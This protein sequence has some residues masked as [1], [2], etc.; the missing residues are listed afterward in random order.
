MDT[1]VEKLGPSRYRLTVK[2]SASEVDE[3]IDQAYKRLARKVKIPGFRAGKAPKPVIDTHIGREAVIADA[4]D[5]LLNESYGR[6]L[7]VEDIRPIANPE[8]GELDLM[9]A[10][11]E[12]E[13]VAEVDVR[14]E[15]TIS[16]PDGLTVT[17]P[18]SQ[19]TDREIDAQIE[20]TRERFATL[21]PVED[22]PVAADDFVLLSFVG[23]IEG[24]A[25]EGNTVDRYLYE[26]NRG[27]M[28]EEFDQAL[29]GTEAGGETVAT[30][31]IP[32]SSSEPKYVGKMAE[33]KITVHEIKAKV[34]PEVDDE[35]AGNV[36]GYENVEEMR[37]A[38]RDQMNKSKAVGHMREVER[39][40]RAALAERLEGEI[41]D[42]MIQSTRSQM[43]R[44]FVSGLESRGIS[45]PDYFKATGGSLGDLE[46]GIAEQAEQAVREELAMEALFRH[47]GWE[48]TDEDIDAEIAE[49]ASSSEADPAELRAKWEET[50]VIAVLR[51]QIM[52]RRAA[53]WLVDPANVTVV[54]TDDP[55]ELAKSRGVQ[56]AE[57]TGT[58]E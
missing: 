17:V 58:E 52:Q 47:M 25:Y 5:E 36:G 6:A 57:E 38:L 35:L 44:D 34:L 23:T 21:E 19:A 50:G 43:M 56:T 11:K 27:L 46:E 42:A 20:H 22:R 53:Q 18:P 41:P 54:E 4:Q 26:M 30:F 37:T 33:F 8:I 3:A 32:A 7:D 14:P 13:F 51:E 9:E 55:V 28:P 40:A 12:F 49:L 16:S 2:L 29:I 10:G 15:L 1:S 31:E 48:I 24:E 39:T 45:L